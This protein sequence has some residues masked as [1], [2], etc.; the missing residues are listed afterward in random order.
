YS[1]LLGDWF[2]G[3]QLHESASNRRNDWRNI[4]RLTDGAEG[5]YDT[6]FL[7]ERTKSS[8]ARMPD[9]KLLSVLSQDGPEFYAG[10]RYADTPEAFLDEIKD[11][12][13]RRMAETG[14]KILPCDS[15]YMATRLQDELGMRSFMPEV[16]CQIPLMRQQTA[17]ARGAARASG[18]TWGV[19]YE[20]W[21]EVRENG[22]SYYSM[23]CFNSDRS[24]EWY[25]TQELHPDD[26]TRDGENG[27]SS[28]ILQNRIYYYALMSG[29]QYFSEEWG[30]NCSYTDMK[31]FT[32]SD[33][34][35][36]KKDFINTAAEFREIE[37]ITPF[38]IV[39]PVRY[40][41]M[42]LPGMFDGYEF[43]KHRGTYMC[44]PLGEE[45]KNYYGH[46]EDVLKLIYLQTEPIGNEG[47]VITNSRFGDIFD[48]V[49]ADASDTVL[50]RYGC[51]IDASPDGGFARLKAGSGMRILESGDFGRLEREIN[52]A[53]KELMPCFS[54]GLCWLVSKDERGRRYLSIFNNEGNE[55]SLQ[56]GNVIHHEADKTV[57]VSFRENVTPHIVKEAMGAASLE[58]LGERSYRAVV[59]AAGFVIIEF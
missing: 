34:G 8:Y 30:L 22:G 24:N 31:E 51:L 52:A 48:I 15:Y 27:G 58:K 35:R 19:Y 26:F 14:G 23:P 12:F 44:C 55:R 18:K 20:C 5:P 39:L 37:P 46:V 25:L 40:A 56:Q 33:Y 4:I 11:M 16:G 54:D 2:L 3:F 50:S 57:T 6:E 17:M 10:L 41:C 45:D 49:Y 29:A 43:G 7:K 13:G 53:A 21:R 42:E 47:H 28:R 32:L 38:A 36:I 9:G 1:E 59:P